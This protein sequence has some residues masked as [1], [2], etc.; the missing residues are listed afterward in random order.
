MLVHRALLWCAAAAVMGVTLPAQ[1]ERGPVVKAPIGAVEG[2]AQGDLLVFK[3]LP[4]AEAPV[5]QARWK[6]PRPVQAWQ[7]VRKATAFGPACFQP[8]VPADNLYA[9][10]PGPM[11]EDCL[12]LNIWTPKTAQNDPVFV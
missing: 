1:A 7:G 3:G 11:S 9:D 12:S 6:P 2:Q 10:D 4:Y 5:G 8:P